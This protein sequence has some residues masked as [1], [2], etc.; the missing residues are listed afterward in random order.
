MVVLVEGMR[1]TWQGTGDVFGSADR[2]SLRGD[3]PRSV[4]LGLHKTAQQSARSFL[5]SG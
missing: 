2:K 5:G 3:V 4:R 1:S